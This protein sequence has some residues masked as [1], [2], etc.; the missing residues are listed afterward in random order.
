MAGLLGMSNDVTRQINVHTQTGS[1]HEKYTLLSLRQVEALAFQSVKVSQ[2]V[3]VRASGSLQP[4]GGEI[5]LI[6]RK[7]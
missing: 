3:A 2:A 4:E 1:R 6:L 5:N 7:D